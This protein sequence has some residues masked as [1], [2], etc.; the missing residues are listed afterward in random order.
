MAT[1]KKAAAK[2]TAEPAPTSTAKSPS[3]T[4]QKPL[5]TGDVDQF[6]QHTFRA[7]MGEGLPP[8]KDALNP[9]RAK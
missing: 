5:A 6:P 8:Q 1:R 2:K 3:S 9:D 4:A 7:D